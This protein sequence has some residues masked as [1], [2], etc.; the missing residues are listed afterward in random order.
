VPND[1]FSRCAC[2]TGY[3]NL[4]GKSNCSSCAALETTRQTNSFLDERYYDAQPRWDDSG[5]CEGAKGKTNIALICPQKGTFFGW[6]CTALVYFGAALYCSIVL[7]C[8]SV[9][10]GAHFWQFAPNSEF[11]EFAPNSEFREF[12]PNSEF[13]E[14]A[15]Y[16]LTV[17]CGQVYTTV[18]TTIPKR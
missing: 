18:W 15:P 12:A 7:H 2:Q 3:Y 10:L 5:V 1:D 11:R 9:L 16:I 17:F 8:N 14:F 4:D 6:M 13:R